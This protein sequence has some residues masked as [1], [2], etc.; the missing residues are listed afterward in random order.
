M[1]KWVNACGGMGGDARED[2]CQPSLRIDARSS[3]PFVPLERGRD[4]RFKPQNCDVCPLGA[5]PASA[6]ANHKQNQ[7]LGC[8][9]PLIVNDGVW[10]SNP[11]CGTNQ[12]FE[13]K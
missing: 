8:V 7:S 12:T 9:D 13:T 11:S 3:L 6:V 1:P 10:G 5:P 2:V 4:V